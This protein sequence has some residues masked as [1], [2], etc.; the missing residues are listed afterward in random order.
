MS[1]KFGVV[2]LALDKEF[3]LCCNYAKGNGEAFLAWMLLYHPRTLLLPVERS[4]GFR[5][6]LTVEGAG[7][8][9]MD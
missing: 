9:Y 7:A 4:S 1:T 2:L 3:S 5:Q 8:A 6:D